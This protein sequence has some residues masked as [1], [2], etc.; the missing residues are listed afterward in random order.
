MVKIGETNFTKMAKILIASRMQKGMTD[1]Q[2]VLGKDHEYIEIYTMDELLAALKI[3]PDQG[4]VIILNA[5]IS[6]WQEKITWKMLDEMSVGQRARSIVWSD[7]KFFREEVKGRGLAFEIDPEPELLMR[8]VQHLLAV[9]KEHV[10][11]H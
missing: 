1:V 9:K 5:S 4:D 6:A 11:I 10:S 7:N 8:A 2:T 3:D